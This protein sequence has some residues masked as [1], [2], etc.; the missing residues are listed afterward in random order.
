MFEWERLQFLELQQL[1]SNFVIHGGVRD[2]YWVWGEEVLGIFT[3]SEFSLVSSIT[4][5]C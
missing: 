4:R 5:Y 1:L 3:V 2:Y